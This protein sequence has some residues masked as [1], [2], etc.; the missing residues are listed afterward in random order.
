M[1]TVE[2]RVSHAHYGEMEKLFHATV[3]FHWTSIMV[4]IFEL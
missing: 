1:H 4:T 3:R 2:P